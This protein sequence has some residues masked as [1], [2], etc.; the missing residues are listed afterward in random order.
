MKWLKMKNRKVDILS[1][2]TGIHMY[3]DELTVR[4]LIGPNKE[5]VAVGIDDESKYKEEMNEEDKQV[6][7]EI[8]SKHSRYIIESFF[9][10]K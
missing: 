5:N 9:E 1:L 2:F 8:M 6:M 4:V 7:K 3:G 10:F